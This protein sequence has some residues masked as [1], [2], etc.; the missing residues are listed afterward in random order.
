MHFHLGLEEY[1]SEQNSLIFK[2]VTLIF[3]QVIISGGRPK[4]WMMRTHMEVVKELV[5]KL[6]C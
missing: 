3:Y 6:V 4:I 1:E 5:M 2:L